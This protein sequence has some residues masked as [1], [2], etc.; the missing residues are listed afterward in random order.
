[1]LNDDN[2]SEKFKRLIRIGQDEAMRPDQDVDIGMVK[3]VLRLLARKGAYLTT[4]RVQKLFYLIEREC[5]LE[6]GERCFNLA[7][8]YDQFGMYSPTLS[9]IINALDRKADRLEVVGI[10][11]EEGIGRTIRCIGR[12]GEPQENPP[13]H[14]VKAVARVLSEWGF[15]KTRALIAAAKSTSPFIYA[16]KGEY[17]DWNMLKE[18]RCEGGEEL[19]P[20]GRERLEQALRSIEQGRVRT[21][22]DTEQ[23]M[24]YLLS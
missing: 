18:E 6:T 10:E 20:K 15:L 19:S 12:R 21:F 13:E 23:L 9:R 24:A 17:L 22:P 16:K 3:R 5:V 8:R 4:S 11:S 2:H 7:Y 1:M 14:V